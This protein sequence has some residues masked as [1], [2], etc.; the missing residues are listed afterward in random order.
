MTLGEFRQLTKTLPN[1]TPMHI[2]NSSYEWYG[3][4]PMN[5]SA[6]R[7]INRRLEFNFGNC[8]EFLYDEVELIT[9]GGL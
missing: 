6:W 1:H 9:K 5:S 7:I 3:E 2:V 4:E 8:R